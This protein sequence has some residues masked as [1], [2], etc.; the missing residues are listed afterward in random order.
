M[1]I[2]PLLTAL[3][4]T[5]TPSLANTDPYQDYDC[6]EIL[7]VLIEAVELEIIDLEEAQTINGHC[8]DLNQWVD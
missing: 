5:T 6:D 1:K 2:L 4:L 3:L 8:L 7:A